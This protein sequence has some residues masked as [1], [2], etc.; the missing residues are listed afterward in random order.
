MRHIPCARAAGLACS[1]ISVNQKHCRVGEYVVAEKGAVDADG[2]RSP[3][4]VL[5]LPTHDSSSSLA[6]WNPG[7]SDR[8]QVRAESGFC[9][10]LHVCAML[11]VYVTERPVLKL[12]AHA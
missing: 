11:C 1:D 7:A 8:A 9:V 6:P 12:V 5:M 10:A 4:A 3:R 2:I